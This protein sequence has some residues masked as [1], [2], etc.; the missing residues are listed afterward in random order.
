MTWGYCDE[1]EIYHKPDRCLPQFLVRDSE[2]ADLCWSVRAHDAED[3]AKR[4]ASRFDCDTY[5]YAIASDCDVVFIVTDGQGPPQRFRMS[6]ETTVN[7][8]ATLEAEAGGA[9]S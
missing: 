9:S 5:E 8:L 3:A 2:D 6:G 7:Y 1:C 4:C